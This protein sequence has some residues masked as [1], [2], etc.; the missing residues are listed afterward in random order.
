[1]PERTIISTKGAGTN[2]LAIAKMS[3]EGGAENSKE[4]HLTLCEEVSEQSSASN[5]LSGRAPTQYSHDDSLRDLQPFDRETKLE[6]FCRY[7]RRGSIVR[8]L[9][10]GNDAINVIK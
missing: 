7:K 4:H 3:V 9:L 5:A 10:E 8:T 6:R 2:S 1:M